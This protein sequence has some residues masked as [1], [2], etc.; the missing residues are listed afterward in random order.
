MKLVTV[1]H[2]LA[3]LLTAAGALLIAWSIGM[4]LQA[5]PKLSAL[6]QAKPTQ[7][8]LATQCRAVATRL[9]FSAPEAGDDGNLR[10]SLPGNDLRKLEPAF[11]RASV[12]VAM[13]RGYE[14]HAFC[15]GTAC[16]GDALFLVL[17]PKN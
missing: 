10:I 17:R 15:A 3:A 5:R 16:G 2:S 6:H 11:D 9:G 12:V 14:M 1:N 8:Q 13:C 4:L 7:A